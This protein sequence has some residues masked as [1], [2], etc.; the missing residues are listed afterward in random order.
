MFCGNCGTQNPDNAPFC[1]GCGAQ[2]NAASAPE[3]SA[4]PRVHTRPRNNKKKLVG[5]I[6]G[7]LAAVAVLLI[8]LTCFG[9]GAATA[10]GAARKAIKAIEKCDGEAYLKLFHK[11][12]IEENCDDKEEQKEYAEYLEEEFEY[13][14]D[15]SF[16]IKDVEKVDKDDLED[17]KEYYEEEYDLKVSNAKVVTVEATYD[18]DT[19][20][21]ELYVIKI[22]MKWYIDG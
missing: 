3:A 1:S 5:I 19:V 14:A 16:K 11:K 10:K 13:M 4:A 15:Y 21:L 12:V 17:I 6:A 18:G 9:R 2:L 8:I 20:E 7:V 22:G